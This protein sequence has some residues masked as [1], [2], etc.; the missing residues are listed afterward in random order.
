MH[1]SYIL[2]V[3]LNFSSGYPCAVMDNVVN[4]K[5]IESGFKLCWR[6]YIHLRINTRR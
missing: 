5:I 1:F 2:S 3:L 6:Y 4:F